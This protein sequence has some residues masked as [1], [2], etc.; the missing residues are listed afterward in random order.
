MRIWTDFP[1]RSGSYEDGIFPQNKYSMALFE[2]NAERKISPIRIWVHLFIIFSAGPPVIFPAS[3]SHPLFDFHAIDVGSPLANAMA[4]MRLE[5]FVCP[6]S[7]L[8][9]SMLS[10]HALVHLCFHYQISSSSFILFLFSFANALPTHISDFRSL[11][12]PP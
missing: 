4:G 11:P 9:L 12:Y 10:E 5:L 6:L 2:W 7:S 1:F 8:V 3:I